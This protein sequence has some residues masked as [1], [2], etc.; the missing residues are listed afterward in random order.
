MKRESARALN[1][2]SCGVGQVFVPFNQIQFDAFVG[3]AQATGV[4]VKKVGFYSPI[5]FEGTVKNA[6]TVGKGLCFG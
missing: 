6:D 2:K 5:F 4:V 3:I 1:G